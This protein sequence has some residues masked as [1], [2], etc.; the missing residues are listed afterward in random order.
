[1][2]TMTRRSTFT[3][4]SLIAAL[5]VL[6]PPDLL[7][8]RE[9]R[10]ARRGTATG[11]QPAGTAGEDSEAS[12]DYRANEMLKKGLEFIEEKQEDR[13]LKLIASIPQMYPKSKV[14]FKAH[15]AL[16]DYYMGK[17]QYDLA[18]KK[19]SEAEKEDSDEIKA[20]SLYKIG[21]CHY[22]MN[23]YDK[24]F[25]VLRQVT[26]KYPWSIY[27]NEAYYYIGLCHFKLNRWARAVEA[28]EMVGTSVPPSDEEGKQANFAE[29]GQ[30]LFVKIH[31]EDL[32]VLAESEQK[33]NVTVENS[34]GDRETVEMGLLGKSLTHYLGSVPTEPGEAKPNDGILQCKG[35]DQIKVSYQD[36]NTGEG[37]QN[38][39]VLST[40]ELVSSASIGF[41]DGAYREYTKGIFGDREFFVRIK[42]LD[43]DTSP[44]PDTVQVKIRSLFKPEKEVDVE[45]TGIDLETVSEEMTERDTVEIT[46]TETGPRTG[47]FTGIG[48]TRIVDL[49]KPDAPGEGLKVDKGDEVILEYTDE[50]HIEGSNPKTLVYKAKALVG[51]IQDVKIEHRRV[52]DLDVR[53]RKNLIEARIFLRL[54]NIFKEV[55]LQK[56]ASE[57]ADEGLDRIEEVL[58]SGIRANVDRSILE[59]AFN[60]K[61]ELLMV[62]DKLQEAIN[63]CNTLI[64]LFPDSSLVD[65]ALMK[66]ADAKMTATDPKSKA[67][68]LNIYNSILRLKQSSLKAEAQYKIA[69]AMENEITERAKANPQAKSDFS[70]AMLAYRMCLEKYPES[71]YAGQA[72]EKISNYYIQA[73]DFQRAVELMEQVF[74]D[75]PDASFLDGMLCKWAIAAFRLG[76]F[77]VA[78]AKC[79]QLI[80]EYP[81]SKFAEKAKSIKAIVEKKSGG[82]SAGEE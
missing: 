44:G 28:L 3:A 7:A 37:K 75:Y 65:V 68:A 18:L 58:K 22:S 64:G 11:S 35:G 81:N 74:Q 33:F 57:K 42:D 9:A 32:V 71:P 8:Q 82:A 23:A 48:K 72:L 66:V 30:R 31:D 16:G 26:N 70:R 79:D 1:M 13:G 78:K 14:R 60:I 61:W 77:D 17:S 29:A 50:R 80:N 4:L 54:G 21:I 59:E 38:Q 43:R 39:K 27:A 12:I 53:S 73:Q 41:T 62:Q 63:V 55:G 6:V 76:Q 25:M 67:D 2:K 10:R 47:M 56:Q 45:K 5:F 36:T 49:E 19:F 20:E 24:A 40:I 34:N 46:L 51:E 52:T 15:L 69:E